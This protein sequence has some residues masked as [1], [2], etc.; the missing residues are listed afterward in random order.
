MNRV[1]VRIPATSANL[2]PGFDCLGIAVS[3]FN[4]ITLDVVNRPVEPQVAIRGEGKD[5]LPRN[6]RNLALRAAQRVL[7]TASKDVFVASITLENAI[8]VGGGLG[9]S[10]AAIVGGMVAANHLTGEA[11]SME[12]LLSLALEYEPHPDNLAPALYG[13]M[14]VAV[15]ASSGKPVVCALPPPRGLKTLVLTP[16][17][18]ISTHQSRATLPATIPFGD[19]AF[20]VGRSSLLVACLLTGCYDKLALAMEDRLHQTYRA[21][22][23]PPMPVILQAALEAGACGAALS[24]SGPSILA[25]YTGSGERIA[26]AM[27]A[28][29][30]STGLR[31]VTRDLEIV[32]G[33][34]GVVPNER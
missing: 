17:Q 34:A 8:P 9:S 3:L 12:E 20:N 26:A 11:L 21:A 24:G 27:T 22:A 15:T 29:A 7:R 31:S 6:S 30:A 19:A 18:A 23:Y 33:G 5:R 32:A 4:H 13:G 1:T 16:D 14:T 28:A 25:L 10:A 2:G